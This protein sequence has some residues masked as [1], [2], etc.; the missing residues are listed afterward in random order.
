MAALGPVEQADDDHHAECVRCADDP[1][2][3]PGAGR[4]QR[5]PVGAEGVVVDLAHVDMSDRPTALET[6][7][8]GTQA[9][10]IPGGEGSDQ[11]VGVRFRIETAVAEQV[12]ETP[13]IG[14]VVE[15]ALDQALVEH[16]AQNVWIDARDL[17]VDG[18]VVDQDL[19]AACADGGDHRHLQKKKI[20]D[21]QAM[22]FP[23]CF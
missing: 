3:P 11:V 21:C 20:R 16:Q 9:I 13:G 7:R 15:D 18:L 8:D 2:H 19:T 6:D 5:L 14:L 4:I 1:V 22:S 23:Y 17:A 10:R 12:V